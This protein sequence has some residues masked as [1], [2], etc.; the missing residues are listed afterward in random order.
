[1]RED[2]LATRLVEHYETTGDDPAVR[3]EEPYD[4][5]GREGVVDLFVRTRT[6]EAVDRVIELKADAAVRRATGANEVLRQYRRM[7][8]YFHADDRHALRPKLGRTEPGA[9]YL[10]C[11]AP[12]P[13]C[14]HHVAVNRTLYGSVDPDAQTGDVPA[15]RTVAF[16]TGLDGDPEDL[17]LVPVN[18]EVGFG[19]APFL[20]A[21]PE[22]SRLAESLR[23]VDDDL[24]EFG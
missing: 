15:V 23:A 11:F 21:V 14:V 12:T 5:D 7:E 16:L 24:V 18:G 10:L 8:R 4:A 1:M 2:A 17:G 9:R 20:R 13:T 22:G 6:P 3:V 19:S